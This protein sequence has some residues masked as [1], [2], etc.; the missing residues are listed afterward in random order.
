MCAM[1]WNSPPAESSKAPSTSRAA[2]WSSA[3]TR[4]ARTTFRPFKEIKTVLVYCASGGRSALSGKTL[5]DPGYRSVFNAGGFKELAD[6]GIETE[7]VHGPSTS[8]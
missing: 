1:R 4:R 5:K 2:C 7:P 8:H 6:A 3:P